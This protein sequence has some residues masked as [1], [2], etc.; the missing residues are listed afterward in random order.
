VS[1]TRSSVAA[2]SSAARTTRA[3]SSSDRLRA[4]ASRISSGTAALSLSGPGAAG[5][6]AIVMRPRYPVTRLQ[7][8]RA[9]AR[10]L[11]AGGREAGGAGGG[12]GIGLVGEGGAQEAQGAG[13]EAG[14]V[15]LGDAEPLGDLGLRLVAPEAEHDQAL[16]AGGQLGVVAPQRG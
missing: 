5:P 7:T 6:P 12:R 15:H 16:L 4:L 3:R 1:A 10:V 13:E 11:G 9:G 2:M 8:C 14:D